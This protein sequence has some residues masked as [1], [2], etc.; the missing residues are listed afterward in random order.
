MKFTESDKVK[1]P[2]DKSQTITLQDL[3]ER[4][5]EAYR[6]WLQRQLAVNAINNMTHAT[7]RVVGND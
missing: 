7:L 4:H 2:D 3:A 1:L 6:W 5:R